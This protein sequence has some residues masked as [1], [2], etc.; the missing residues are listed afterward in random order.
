MHPFDEWYL[1]TYREPQPQGTKEGAVIAWNAA[2]NAVIDVA[3]AAKN[4]LVQDRKYE[5]AALV[6]DLRQEMRGVAR[7]YD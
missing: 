5:S 4:Q 7:R 1:R 6:F 3:T 2:V